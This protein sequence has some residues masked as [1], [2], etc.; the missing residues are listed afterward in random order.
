MVAEDTVTAT[1]SRLEDI[2]AERVGWGDFMKTGT[3][4]IAY[5]RVLA[6]IIIQ[7]WLDEIVV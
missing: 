2:K 5:T 1:T 7:H 4:L 6:L 3:F